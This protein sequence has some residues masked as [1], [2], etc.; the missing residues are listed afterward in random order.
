[1]KHG[2]ETTELRLCRGMMRV[3][4]PEVGVVP[5]DAELDVLLPA[6]R[7]AELW[8]KW[9]LA[10]EVPLPALDHTM[11]LKMGWFAGGFVVA[12]FILSGMKLAGIPMPV[13][14]LVGGVLGVV[15]G[16][17]GLRIF[18]GAGVEFPRGVKTIHDLAVWM[19]LQRAN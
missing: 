8:K 9:E 18:G 11:R 2:V 5:G 13:S 3:L 7:R 17:L 4:G 15:L 12:L 1:M 14:V 6:E 16:A 10:A 19:E